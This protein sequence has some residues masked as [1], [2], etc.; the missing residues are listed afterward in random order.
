MKL[1]TGSGG[2]SLTFIPG[3]EE[4]GRGE[5]EEGRVWVGGM[6]CFAYKEDHLKSSVEYRV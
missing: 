4:D 3:V 2:N 5:G 1:Q 6:G